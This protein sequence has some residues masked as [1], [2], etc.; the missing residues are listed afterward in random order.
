MKRPALYL[1]AL[2]ALLLMAAI[3]ALAQDKIEYGQSLNGTI[4]DA[5]YEVNYTFVGQTDDVAVI[6]MDETDILDDLNNP[7]LRLLGPDGTVLATACSST[8]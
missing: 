6:V 7:A 8:R 2:T 4:S 5:V 1:L 3:P